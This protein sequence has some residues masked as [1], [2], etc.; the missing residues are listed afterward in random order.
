M[1]STFQTFLVEEV[2]P[3]PSALKKVKRFISALKN[4]GYKG[5]EYGL[6]YK[7]ITPS[8][9]EVTLQIK[10]WLDESEKKEYESVEEDMKQIAENEKYGAD[11]HK[12][13]EGDQSWF[14]GDIVRALAMD[15]IKSKGSIG[16]EH[17][18]SQIQLVLTFTVPGRK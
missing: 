7:F 6:E 5:H 3:E 2:T 4:E 8:K 14:A 1:K 9:A 16:W 18:V 12:V 15:T 11:A 17:F 13:E 10:R